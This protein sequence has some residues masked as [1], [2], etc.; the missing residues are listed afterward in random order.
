MNTT[1]AETLYIFTSL[2]NC[3]PV[4]VGKLAE[5]KP[6]DR[7]QLLA[8]VLAGLEDDEQALYMLTA[9]STKLKTLPDF[10]F[11]T[12]NGMIKRTAAADYDVRSRKYPALSL[13]KDDS[14]LDVRPDD[15]D[16]DVLL[17]TRGGMSI[18]FPLSGVPV[19]GRTASGV[20]A[21]TVDADD[22]VCCFRQIA[23]GDE[24]VLFSERG[25][26]KR[27]PQLDFETQ[28]RSGKGVR[29]FYF[30]KNGSNGRA[31]AGVSLLPEKA[32]CTLLV[33]QLRSP[34]TKLNKNEI[35]LQNRSGKGMPYIMAILDDVVTAVTAIIIPQD[36]PP[37]GV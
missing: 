18:R 34:V 4:N 26:A 36:T 10:L 27:I 8:G 24:V 15:G 19:Q 6:R 20:R 7:G 33:S 31:I 37:E 14:L 9:D 29:C 11:V 16:R 5:C 13:K 3:Y 1:T 23:K 17:I 21:M 30:N 12:R 32:N 25:W 2:G 28:N 22:E 35:L